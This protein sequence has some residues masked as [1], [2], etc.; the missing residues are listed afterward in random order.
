[1]YIELMSLSR[2]RKAVFI[3]SFAIVAFAAVYSLVQPSAFVATMQKLNAIIL[4][5]FDWLFSSAALFF[6]LIVV[7]LYFSPAGRVRVGGSKAK[8]QLTKFRWFAI[9]LSTTIASGILFWGPMEP[10]YHYHQPPPG[11][12]ITPATPEAADFAMSTMFMHWSFIP[13][14][15]Y[16][17]AA[18][19]FAIG[20]YNLKGPFG[21]SSLLRPLAGVKADKLGNILNVLALFALVAGMAASLGAGI[22]VLSGGVTQL[23]SIRS[24]PLLFGVITILVVL[25]FTI[26]AT[27]GL[28]KG[29]RILSTW[30]VRIFIL[31]AGAMLLLG[32]TTEI[33]RLTGRGVSE[34]ITTFPE[35]SMIGFSSENRE[36]AGDWT[37]FYWAN[38]L[39]WTPITAVFLGRISQGRTIREVI[40]F[41]LLYPSLFGILWMGIFSG[42]AL[43]SASG[44]DT[45]WN[46]LDSGGNAG[47]II[48][49]LF[50]L[51]PIAQVLSVIYLITSFLSYVTA[52]DSNTS[53]MSG[54]SSTGISPQNQEPPKWIQVTWGALIGIIAWVMISFGG[55]EDATGLDGIRMLSN[56]GGLPSLFT[57]IAVSIGIVFFII[58]NKKRATE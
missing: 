16:T 12:H 34:F 41:N 10:L 35:R 18:V 21:L 24:S 7:V 57:M 39:A 43:V 23:T 31:I 36:W 8:P 52:A 40:R 5:T 49:A 42:S 26:S 13:Y 51:L 22:L 6:L 50:E 47:E 44:S 19:A 3:P 55:G 32:P 48:F 2:L 56:L 54:I 33:L 46:I 20:Y 38:W 9:T 11:L 15:I 27:S 53:A 4:N 58:R 14:G 28:Q 37:I 45:L 30:N 29:I 25:A 1:M 17:L